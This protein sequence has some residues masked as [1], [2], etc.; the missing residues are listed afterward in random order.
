[1][2]E[3][4]RFSK[5]LGFLEEPQGPFSLGYYQALARLKSNTT[6]VVGV[7]LRRVVLQGCSVVGVFLRRA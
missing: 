5:V 2:F 4:K 3:E 6:R 1:M 7:F